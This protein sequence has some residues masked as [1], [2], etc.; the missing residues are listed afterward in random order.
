MVA[1]SST[2]DLSLPDGSSIVIEER[3]G[4]EVTSLAGTPISPPSAAAFNPTFDVTPADRVTAVVTE[5]GVL[6]ERR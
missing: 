5:N 4:D 6:G 3:P 1:P 2:V